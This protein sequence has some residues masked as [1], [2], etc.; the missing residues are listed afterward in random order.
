MKRNFTI[1]LQH[2]LALTYALFIGAALGIL[3][4]AIN[5]FTG[6]T[7]TAL[8]KENISEKSGEIVRAIE[9]LYNPMEGSFD[10]VTTEAIGMYFVHEGYIVTV[11]DEGK[12]PV[13][14]ARSCDMQ[15]CVEV[16]NDIAVRMEQNFRLN[17]GMQKQRHPVYYNNRIVG[18]VNIETYGPFFYSETETEFLRS[19]NR[20]LL[21]AGVILAL[22]SAGISLLLSRSIAK[23]ILKAG[24]AARKIAQVHAP[25][26]APSGEA[27]PEGLIIRINEQYRTRELQDL[28]R[29]INRLAAELEEGER[30]QKQ[31]TSDIAHELRTPLTC[32]QGNI[33]AM[34]DGVYKPDREHLES[35][36]EEII[37][38]TN[39]VNDLNILTS[40]EVV[41]KKLLPLPCEMSKNLNKT[42]F[43]LAKL[44]QIT[45]EQFRAAVQEK[46][47]ALRL[48][49]MESPIT[50]DY[51]RLK[52]VFMNLLSN[53]VKYTDS[54]SITVSIERGDPHWDIIVAD[55]GIGIPEKDIPH[56]FERFYRTD[57]SRSRS[58]G[59]AGIGLAIAAAIISAHGGTINVESKSGEGGG[60]GSIFRVRL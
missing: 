18:T 5:I 56:I 42:S 54:G 24:E 43:D 35:C 20:L 60:T 45:A 57:K 47:I 9:A 58:T 7:F 2:R 51:D 55:T 4:L 34:I 19:I 28:S 52:Q 39:L 59:G 3:T 30:R 37:R 27:N 33:E 14:D 50:A 38:L 15:Q 13:W 11:E 26:T 46:G 32:L 16:I 53:A 44:V 8:I 41:N 40:L 21:F 29:S 49:L 22:L 31:L 48:C 36:H 10:R 17:G 1:S 12:E 23:P 6:I 25:W